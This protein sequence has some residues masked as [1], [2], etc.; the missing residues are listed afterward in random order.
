MRH[1]T[2][3][4]STTCRWHSKYMSQVCKIPYVTGTQNT[5]CHRCSESNMSQ[6]FSLML[7]GLLCL[8]VSASPQVSASRE[9]S[10]SQIILDSI[11]RQIATKPAENK[12]M[13]GAEDI[14]SSGQEFPVSGTVINTLSCVHWVLPSEYGLWVQG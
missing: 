6:V 5:T 1:V 3:T 11:S 12:V 13:E 8:Q 4:Q 9:L 14:G 10:P 7:T 2:G